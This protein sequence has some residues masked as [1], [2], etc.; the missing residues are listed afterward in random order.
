MDPRSLKARMGRNMQ[1]SQRR[2]KGYLNAVCDRQQAWAGPLLFTKKPTTLTCPG[3]KSF[4]IMQKM[5]VREKCSL[6]ENYGIAFRP[7][8]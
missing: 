2:R 6:Y 7:I 4:L 8:L 3:V 1:P 5:S